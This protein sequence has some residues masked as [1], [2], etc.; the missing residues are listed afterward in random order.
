MG[1]SQLNQILAYLLFYWFFLIRPFLFSL[2]LSAY[3]K[4]HNLSV[5][6][7]LSTLSLATSSLY[8]LE[9]RP[10]YY[11]HNWKMVACIWG[12]K[13][14]KYFA[15]LL[16]YAKFMMRYQKRELLLKELFLNGKAERLLL[17]TLLLYIQ[18]LDYLF[19]ICLLIRLEMFSKWLKIFLVKMLLS[20]KNT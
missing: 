12:R 13:N 18:Q 19:A 2:S 10:L 4:S 15:G 7:F 3:G 5:L 14:L 1:K 6:Q 9:N 20:S 11:R 17:A 16:R 8:P